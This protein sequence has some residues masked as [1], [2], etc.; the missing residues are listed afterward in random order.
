MKEN[1]QI[2]KILKYYK[3]KNIEIHL[4]TLSD[5]FY[6][7]KILAIEDDSVI[8]DEKRYGKIMILYERIKVESI[9]PFTSAFENHNEK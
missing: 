5:F 4:K 7:G 9:V 8:L 1:K 3:D 2:K 6:N